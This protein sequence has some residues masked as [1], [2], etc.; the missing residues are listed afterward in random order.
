MEGARQ[1]EGCR[2]CGSKNLTQLLA[3]GDQYLTSFPEEDGGGRKAP[4]TLLMCEQCGLVQLRHTCPR[5]WLY[6]W[7]GYR[8]GVNASMRRALHEITASASRFL[9]TG[10]TV[11]DIGSNDGTLLRSYNVMG[12]RK[13][14]FEPA[15][16]LLPEAKEG[17]DLLVP[18]YFNF[19]AVKN[20]SAS[21]VTAIAMFYDLDDPV[22][23]LRDVSALLAPGGVF[24]VQ[25]N[26][27]L[28]M[29]EGAVFDNISHEHVAYYSLRTFRAVAERAGLEVFDVEMNDVNGG[30]LRAYCHNRGQG[31]SDQ[32]NYRPGRVRELLRVEESAGLGDPKT[33][34]SFCTRV[35]AIVSRL[36]SM[37]RGL[38]AEGKKVYVYGASTR[39]LV[40]MQACG[41]DS[42]LISGAAEKNREKWGRRYDGT[43]IVCVPEQEA[44]DKADYFL[45]L[46]WQFVNEF[47][48]R[49]RAFLESGGKF[50]VPLP[51]VRIIGAE[52]LA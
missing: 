51:E 13:I 8:S 10:D 23:F 6:S 27:L 12:L 17:L 45:V 42:S 11:V 52:D 50:I 21:V 9:R 25:M 30:S 24:I 1:I 7:Y 36:Q 35:N 40:V 44:R 16:N 2:V 29:V 19:N 14:G 48:E 34:E 38:V 37:V 5:E 47:K 20:E 18:D 26:Y 46:P 43:G 33:Y 15:L 22:E 32:R 4:L 31:L 39:G 49:E 3:L 28:P 41:I